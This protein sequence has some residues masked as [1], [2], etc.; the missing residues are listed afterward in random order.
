MYIGTE[1][2]VSVVKWIVCYK[3]GTLM[4]IDPFPAN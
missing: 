3:E 2:T 4:E 1:L